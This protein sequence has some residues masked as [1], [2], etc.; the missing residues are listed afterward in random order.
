MKNNKFDREANIHD[1]I[2]F[3]KKN[4]NGIFYSLN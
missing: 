2:E 1:R 4:F 3:N